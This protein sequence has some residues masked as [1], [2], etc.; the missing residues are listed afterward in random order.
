MRNFSVMGSRHG[1]KPFWRNRSLRSLR[2]TKR[3]AHYRVNK[4][5]MSHM[6]SCQYLDRGVLRIALGPGGE[7]LRVSQFR[8]QEIYEDGLNDDDQ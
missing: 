1:W 3:G 5:D 2:V 8:T 4:I 7:I 6:R